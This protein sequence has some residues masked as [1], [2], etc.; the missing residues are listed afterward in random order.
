MIDYDS[1]LIEMLYQ[2]P[3]ILRDEDIKYIDTHYEK[4]APF[5]N[6]DTPDNDDDEDIDIALG[7][8]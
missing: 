7:S 5:I 1:Y 3:D 8:V 4:F 2:S 6:D